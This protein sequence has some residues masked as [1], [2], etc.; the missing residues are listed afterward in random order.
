MTADRD[1]SV[2]IWDIK[3]GVLLSEYDGDNGSAC[4]ASFNNSGE[5]IV[6][7]YGKEVV[8][9]WDFPSLQNLINRTNFLFQNRE[10]TQEEKDKF[11]LE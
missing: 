9:I 7:G 2:K 3:S 11:H 8:K 5:K 1:G 4:Y 6:V 10:L